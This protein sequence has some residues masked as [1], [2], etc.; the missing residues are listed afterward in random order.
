MHNPSDILHVA[1]ALL[2]VDWIGLIGVE[3]HFQYLRSYRGGLFYWQRKPEYPVETADIQQVTDV[4]PNMHT[5]IYICSGWRHVIISTMLL[6][7]LPPRPRWKEGGQL[8]I[9]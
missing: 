2:G 7:H 9:C 5:C 4:L 8:Q 6:S 3:R 1:A